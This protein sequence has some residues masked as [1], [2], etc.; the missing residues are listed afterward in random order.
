MINY[1]FLHIK[2]SNKNKQ[3]KQESTTTIE[4]QNLKKTQKKKHTHKHTKQ[5]KQQ[6][7]N[8]GDFRCTTPNA[9]YF[10]RPQHTLFTDVR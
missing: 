7:K 2:K 4:K 10:T 1:L 6:T 3:T 8:S 9:L 5:N